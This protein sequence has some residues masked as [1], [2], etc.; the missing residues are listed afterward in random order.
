MAVPASWGDGSM[1]CTR[2]PG[3]RSGGVTSVHVSPLSVLTWN[4]PSYDPTQIT[5]RRT[6]LSSMA[7][8]V[9]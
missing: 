8:S 4:G 1:D 9:E 2:P 3:G 5:P 6:G 7:Y